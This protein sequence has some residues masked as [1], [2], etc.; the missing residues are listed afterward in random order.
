MEDGAGVLALGVFEE[1]CVEGAGGV[2]EG[3]EHDPAA[4]ADGWG[5]G[6]DFHAGDE[7]FGPVGMLAEVAGPGSFQGLQQGGVEVEDVAAGVQAEDVEF[8]ADAF[9]AGHLGQPGQDDLVGDIAQVE[10]HLHRLLLDGQDGAGRLGIGGPRPYGLHRSHD[11]H[12]P[13]HRAGSPTGRVLGVGRVHAGRAWW[14]GWSGST[15]RGRRVAGAGR[16]G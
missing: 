8:G 16:G 5:L 15:V 11:R 12:P 2:V 4:A 13:G 14:S 10:G 9:G 3:E 7:E 1:G 6:R